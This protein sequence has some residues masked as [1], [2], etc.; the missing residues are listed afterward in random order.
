LILKKEEKERL[1]IQLAMEVKSTKTMAKL[2]HVPLKDIG[3]II[4]NYNGEETEYQNKTL[5]V[6]SK[7]FQ[8]F[9]EGKSRVDVEIELDIESYETISVFHDYLQFINLDRLVTTYQYLGINL[10]KFLELF[11]MMKEKGIVTQPATHGKV[12]SVNGKTCKVGGR[13]KI[14]QHAI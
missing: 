8:M 6:T 11:D 3:T 5:S 1:V 9:K 12:C 10:S 4:R 14:S 2:L 13:I 7:D